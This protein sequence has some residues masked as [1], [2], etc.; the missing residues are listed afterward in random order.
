MTQRRPHL[1]PPVLTGLTPT[2]INVE[3]KNQ[4]QVPK[5]LSRADYRKHTRGCNN[6]TPS[7]PPCIAQEEARRA[8]AEVA[9]AEKAA[10][11]PPAMPSPEETNAAARELATH[12]V[13]VEITV[14]PPMGAHVCPADAQSGAGIMFAE[15]LAGSNAERAGVERGDI[16]LTI[17]GTSVVAGEHSTCIAV[18]QEQP[19][20]PRVLQVA[21][22]VPGAAP[23]APEKGRAQPHAR[24]CSLHKANGASLGIQLTPATAEGNGLVVHALSEDGVAK[25]GGVVKG[26]EIASIFGISVQDLPYDQALAV[27]SSKPVD[28][29][30]TNNSTTPRVSLCSGGKFSATPNHY[31][32]GVQLH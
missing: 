1:Y 11:E 17:N 23:A 12:T 25:R 5:G 2:L 20:G 29:D 22:V 27:I 30:G 8:A 26:D 7:C 24:E 28:A 10:A 16:V 6:G 15:V 9:R 21:R 13:A 14:E 32:S 4:R 19:A 18:L 31:P 3:D